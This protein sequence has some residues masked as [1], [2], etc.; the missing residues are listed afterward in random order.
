MLALMLESFHLGRLALISLLSHPLIKFFTELFFYLGILRVARKIVPLILIF[1]TIIKL[2][3]G[4][5]HVSRAYPPNTE[6]V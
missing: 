5:V 1:K 4:P 6:A 2:L 3:S